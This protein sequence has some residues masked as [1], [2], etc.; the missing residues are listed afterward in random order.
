MDIAIAAAAL[1]FDVIKWI[2]EL[3]IHKFV[4]L[5]RNRKNLKNTYDKKQKLIKRR[6]R[7]VF[8]SI[9]KDNSNKKIILASELIFALKNFK[10][11][12][13]AIGDI[14]Y[15]KYCDYVNFEGELLEP[16]TKIEIIRER[17]ILDSI[18]SCKS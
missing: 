4:I 10:S 8:Y 9:K 2:I 6:L 11:E 14:E 5:Q 16:N 17:E 3:N 13:E 18:S 7:A 15:W 12:A 1:I